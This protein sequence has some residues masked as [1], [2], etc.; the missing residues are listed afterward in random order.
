MECR[1]RVSGLSM[2]CVAFALVLGE[3]LGFESHRLAGMWPWACL[4]TTLLALVWLG[5]DVRHLRWPVAALAGV[6]LSWRC[7]TRRMDVEE[8][9][10]SPSADG[11]PPAYELDVEGKVSSR[12]R[13]SKD[14]RLVTFGS[15]VDGVPVRVVIRMGMVGETPKAGE[16][17]RCH[18]WLS[19]R[20]G[21]PSRYSCRTLWVLGGD[22]MER[23]APA[24]GPAAQAAY[25]S[26]SDR[27][28]AYG[29]AGLVWRR[30]LALTNM[31]MLLGRRGGVGS[32]KRAAFAAAGTMHVFAI[33]GL[34][35]ML[36]AGALNA[37]L[38][39]AGLS[40]SMQAALCI[41][42]LAA[43][44][45]LTGARASAIR[46]ALMLSLWFGARLFGR[47]PDSLA[48]LGV[49]AIIVYA[50]S[51]AKVFDVGCGL[52]FAVILGILLW[53]RWSSR[54]AL[55]FAGALEWAAEERAL[56]AEGRFGALLCRWRGRIMW[57]LG[58]LGVSL[59]SWIASTP[60]SAMVFGRISMGGLVAN[61]A[62][63]PLATMS[64]LFSAMGVAASVVARPIGA[65]FNNL[66]ACCTW[67]MEWVSETVAK[68]PGASFE[69]YP[70]S[71]LECIVWYAAWI[72]IFAVAARNLRPRGRIQ[73]A[74]WGRR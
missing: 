71:W 16:R 6:A 30:E 40:P 51:P 11:R 54:F 66:A 48:A 64:V 74:H 13:R 25:R 28:A 44:V 59:A 12:E 52:S 31:A 60:I 68:C 1:A 3:G 39:K 8:R 17:W 70:W 19:L 37:L 69:T 72:G 15:T 33:S 20:Q 36:I 55:P 14:G 4:C 73:M 5:W 50:Y 47:K 22:Q 53:I 32:D 26:A 49:T 61:V 18:G 62:V 34:H 43:Y 24:A 10:H 27:M 21:A 58:M 45:M 42:L 29:E 41:P 2:V 67:M 46:A 57:V 23:I 63:V 56:G 35:V 65:L 7:E 9:S 38:K